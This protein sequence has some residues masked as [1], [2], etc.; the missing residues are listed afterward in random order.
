MLD[1]FSDVTL[2]EKVRSN[3]EDDLRM[4]GIRL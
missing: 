2:S 4:K 3:P 1:L